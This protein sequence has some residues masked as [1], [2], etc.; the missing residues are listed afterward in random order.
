MKYPT[1]TELLPVIKYAK[2]CISDD[3]YIE[4]DDELPGITLTIG[5]NSEDGMYNY[6]HDWSYQTGDNQFEGGAYG[7]QH[8]AV[9]DIY[10][11]DNARNLAKELISQ[12]HDLMY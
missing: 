2:S 4:S 7:Y 3:C 12:L 1:I 6:K 10:R 5:W 11:R 9:V 8:W